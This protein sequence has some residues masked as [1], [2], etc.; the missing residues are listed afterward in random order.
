MSEIT[1]FD[2]LDKDQYI[3]EIVV[4]GSER[5][6]HGFN[7]EKNISKKYNIRKTHKY[8]GK[9]DG[10]LGKT[11][12]SIKTSKFGTDIE[13]SDIFRQME[14]KEDF[15][16]FVG[17][18]QK[19]KNNI[20]KE[21]L[22]YIPWKEWQKH[23][24]KNM[25][26]D[27]LNLLKSVSNHKEDDFIWQKRTKLLKE[28][29]T[30]TTTNMIRPRFKRDHKKQK[31]IQCAINYDLF[32][33]YFAKK[34]SIKKPKGTTKAQGRKNKFDKFFTKE[35]VAK[36]CI[37]QVNLKDFD[38]IIEPS[39]GSGSFSNQIEGCV[40]FDIE[41]ENE[42]II[43]KD[44][45][46]Y[47]H[48]ERKGKTLVIGNPPFGEQ[49]NLAVSFFNHSSNFAS[50]IAFILPKS[51]KKESIQSRL[52]KNFHL[53]KEMELEEKSFELNNEDYSVSTVFQ[54]WE[55]R[56]YQRKIN[57]SKKTSYLF[58]FTKKEDADLRIPRVGGNAGKA[59]LSLDAAM[60]SNYFIKNNSG[61]SNA[62]FV[63][64]VN[65]LNFPSINHT[66]GPRSLPKGEL[67]KVVEDAYEKK[68]L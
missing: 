43:K 63:D 27:F 47:Q 50:T 42:K 38:T 33:S 26:E 58:D 36:K 61:L 25:V 62:D 16:L 65:R 64:F 12:V 13:M 68:D 34:F 14:I 24:N 45:F 7:Y 10:H 21:Y 59:T 19:N 29:W 57:K 15:Y 9:W 52:N 67:I 39:A 8:N 18:W 55:K 48:P 30:L 56:D 2:F 23:F 31:R 51:F 60:P 3:E 20:V 53:V 22:L 11:P 4:D 41:P 44:W 54:V 6:S 5:Q 35:S 66:T 32:V 37:D 40:A 28:K 49:N 17:F 46:K 1:I